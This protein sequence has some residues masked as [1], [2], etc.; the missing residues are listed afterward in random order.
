MAPR[1]GHKFIGAYLG[2]C[3][4]WGFCQPSLEYFKKISQ[5]SLHYFNDDQI[6]SL[7]SLY[8]KKGRKKKSSNEE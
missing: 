7:G 2:G 3:K 8:E 4:Y 6:Q 5:F 1:C